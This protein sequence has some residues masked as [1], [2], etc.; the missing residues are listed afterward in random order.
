MRQRVF[1]WD[2]QA[3]GVQRV[4]RVAAPAQPWGLANIVHEFQA[5]R[6]KRAQGT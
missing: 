3:P 2:V 4:L 5:R 6:D 1:R